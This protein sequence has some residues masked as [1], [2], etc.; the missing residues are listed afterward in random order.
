MDEERTVDFR[1]RRF[2]VEATSVDGKKI[3]FPQEPVITE[4][5]PRDF[6]K[7]NGRVFEVPTATYHYLQNLPEVLEAR[8]KRAREMGMAFMYPDGGYSC[9]YC[10]HYVNN[11]DKLLSQSDGE[12]VIIHN[13]QGE[14]KTGVTNCLY[15]RVE[16][17]ARA[18]FMQNEERGLIVIAK[19]NP[20][21]V[22]DATILEI[23]ERG[24]FDEYEVDRE[25]DFPTIQELEEN[26]KLIKRFL[27][28]KA[29]VKGWLNSLFLKFR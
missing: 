17:V 27:M 20:C 11:L 5:S 26:P 25:F 13:T 9:H 21:V 10:N 28:G 16:D 23:S 3:P 7:Y 14:P 24:Y 8:I 18:T 12:E 1:G 6:I 22:E 15:E 4:D 29:G 19:T 2:K